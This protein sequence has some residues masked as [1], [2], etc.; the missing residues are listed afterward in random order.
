MENEPGKARWLTRLAGTLAPPDFESSPLPNFRIRGLKPRGYRR[1]LALRGGHL[2]AWPP[3]FFLYG[4]WLVFRGKEDDLRE[5]VLHEGWRGGVFG[6]I[7]LRT[8]LLL[9]NEEG[10]RKGQSGKRE[11]GKAEMGRPGLGPGATRCEVAG[12]SRTCLPLA[13]SAP[14]AV[15]KSNWIRLDQTKSNQKRACFFRRRNFTGGRGDGGNGWGRCLGTWCEPHGRL[16]RPSKVGAKL[17]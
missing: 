15:F 11:I 6:L 8:G 1:F 4:V 13:S 16:T 3:T 14:G 2:L 9:C 12:P 10:R 7:V 17:N 5:V